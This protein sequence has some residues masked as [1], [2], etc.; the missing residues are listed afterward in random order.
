MCIS[1]IAFVEDNGFGGIHRITVL[2]K[3]QGDA[4]RSGCGLVIATSPFLF[5]RHIDR[6]KSVDEDEPVSEEV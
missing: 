5:N 1:V 3:L 6:I 2:Q 4:F